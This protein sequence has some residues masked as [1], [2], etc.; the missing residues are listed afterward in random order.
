MKAAAFRRFG[1]P[2]VLEYMDL[3]TPEPR[4]GN[5]LVKVLASGVNRLE[6]YL[7]EGSVLPDLKLPH[8]LGSDAAGEVAALGAG[9]RIFQPGQRV[10]PMPGYP[11]DP[12]D[13]RFSPMSAAPSYAIGGIVSW[14][15]YA[16]Y[17]EVPE[18]WLL[19]DDTGLAAQDLATLPMVLVTAV[20]AVRTV[21]AVKAGDHVLVH[22][23]AS[24]TGSMNLQ[25]ARALGARVAVTVDDAEKGRLAKTL[26]AELIVDV[27]SRDVVR[28]LLDWTDGKGV[29]VAIDNLGGD[30]LQKSIDATRV[31]G[32]IVAMGFVAGVEVRF[33]IR[34]FFFTQKR[35]LGT[36]MGDTEDLRW[37]LQQVK[38]GRIQPLLDRAL[39][40]SE[41]AEAHRLIAANAVKGN[42]VLVP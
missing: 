26:G 20:R 27:R 9:A 42:V 33:H 25:V 4:A 41:A 32:T 37:G 35:L 7:R 24:G 23:G 31:H 3:P 13:E 17:V 1:G 39:P 15:T 30:V 38:A 5:V 21:G 29:D 12:A 14:G 11:L 8:V 40:L 16:Q 34:N 28:E 36:L 18:R 19:A 22:A 6:H 10:V 2:E